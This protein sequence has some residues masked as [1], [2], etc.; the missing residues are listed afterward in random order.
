[1]KNHILVI[2]VPRPSLKKQ[3]RIYSDEKTYPCSQFPKDISESG[4]LKKHFR[5]HSGKKTYPCH[6]GQ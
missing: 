2:N 4:A 6:Q 5:L 3:L 1:M